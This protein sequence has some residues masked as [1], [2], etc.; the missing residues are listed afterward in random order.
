MAHLGVVGED[1]GR[2]PVTVR[3][4]KDGSFQAELGHQHLERDDRHA[5]EPMEW[6]ETQRELPL[7]P[8]QAQANPPI[9]S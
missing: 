6:E 7:Q 9:P 8:R 5:S 4:Q 3:S 2:F 1:A